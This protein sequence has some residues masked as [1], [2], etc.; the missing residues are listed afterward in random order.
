MRL[1]LWMPLTSVAGKDRK[2]KMV[3]CIDIRLRGMYSGVTV[4]EES[5]TK[6]SSEK[7]EIEG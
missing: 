3:Y 2:L 7:A 5:M 4:K 1:F 6:H